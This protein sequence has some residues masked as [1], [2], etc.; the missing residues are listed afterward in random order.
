MSA[1]T[2]RK[3]LEILEDAIKNRNVLLLHYRSPMSGNRSERNIEPLG[4]YFT[5]DKW[6]LV[7]FCRLRTEKREFRLDGLVSLEKTGDTFPPHQFTFD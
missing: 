4:I 7:A 6:M 2:L 3:Y 5:Q 1:D